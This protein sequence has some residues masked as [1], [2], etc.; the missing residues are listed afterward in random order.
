[1]EQYIT[2]YSALDALA[3]NTALLQS[4]VQVPHDLSE[5]AQKMLVEKGLSL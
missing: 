4:S 5:Q 2:G 3:I 1:V